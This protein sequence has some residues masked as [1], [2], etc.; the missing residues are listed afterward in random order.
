MEKKHRS[1]VCVGDADI[2][3]LFYITDD[4]IIASYLWSAVF[5]CLKYAAAGV[6]SVV[7]ESMIILSL[8]FCSLKV[9]LHL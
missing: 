7:T 9:E 2:I 4:A 1:C 8:V 6:I 5:N 3:L